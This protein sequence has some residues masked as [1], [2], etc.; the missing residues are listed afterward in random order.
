M[1]ALIRTYST[2]PLSPVPLYL[3]LMHVYIDIH[4]IITSSQLGNLQINVPAAVTCR[5]RTSVSA[6]CLVMKSEVKMHKQI[7]S[8]VTL[9]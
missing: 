8:V 9:D 4:N 2:L 1:V 3:S 7:H 6:V 5:F